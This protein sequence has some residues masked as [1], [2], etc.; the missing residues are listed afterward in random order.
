M[1]L[2]LHFGKVRA[3][4]DVRPVRKFLAVTL[5]VWSEDEKE[6]EEETRMFVFMHLAH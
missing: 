5:A 2:R 3:G 1:W 4:A 6:E